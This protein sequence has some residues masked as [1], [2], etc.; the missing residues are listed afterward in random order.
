MFLRLAIWLLAS[1]SLTLVPF[2]TTRANEATAAIARLLD[3]GWS[4]KP[5]A[6]AAADAQLDEVRRLAGADLRALEASWLVLMQQRRFDEALKRIDEHL[7]KEPDDLAAWRAKTWVQAVLKNYAAAFLSADRLSNLIAS[8]PAMNDDERSAQD[9]AIGF[10]GRLIGYFGG[11]AAD[12]VNQDERKTLERKVLE[13]LEAS[14]R[15]LFENARNAVLAKFIEMTDDSADAREL[16]VAAAQAEKEKTLADIQTE[17]ERIEA[18]VKELEERRSKLDSE[19]KSELD[20]I[21]KQELPLVDQQARLNSQADLLNIELLGYSS[22][23]ATLQDLAAKEKDPKL[24]QNYLFQINSLTFAFSRI[25]A[26]LLAIGRSVARLQS[27][28]AGLVA[29]RNQAQLA[30]ANQIERIERDL[31]EI[32]K[33]ERRND[34]I[35][36]RANRTKAPSNGKSRALAAQATALSTYDEFPL[37]AA[38]VK[39]LESL[40]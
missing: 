1:G 2:T 24:K 3:V 23:I 33:R 29:R 18:R 20:S 31:G 7:V 30:T 4:I 12:N 6:R 28:R 15:P 14:K 9:D 10:L 22:Q 35:E 13:R 38:K 17:R 5:Q 37:E 16:A 34:G 19:L 11:P 26:D 40:R 27:Q 21:A 39:L 32:N 25:D 36:K 8:R